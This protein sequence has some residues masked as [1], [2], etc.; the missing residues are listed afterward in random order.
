MQTVTVLKSQTRRVKL[1]RYILLTLF[2]V[3]MY[4][5]QVVMSHLP[6]F[7]AVSLLIIVTTCLLGVKAL[8]SVY[9]FVICEIFTYGLHIW[10]INYLY[11]WAILVIAV[12][13]T[14]K[15]ASRE[16]FALLSAIF[17]LLFGT[18]CSIPYFIMGGFEGGIVYIIQGFW[19]DIL[20]C[21]GNLVLTFILFNP[22]TNVLDKAIKRY[23]YKN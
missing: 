2:G 18:F 5:T 7:E 17:G 14:R 10:S 8:F 21:V 12:L 20:H 22:L 23:S 1:F 11:V 15:F 9:I 3:L 4:V 16:F 19:F 13:C 6:N